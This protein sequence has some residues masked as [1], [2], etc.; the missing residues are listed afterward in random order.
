MEEKFSYL[1]LHNILSP[2]C[3]DG[4]SP[5]YWSKI[6]GEDGGEMLGK[7]KVSRWS[8]TYWN[9]DEAKIRNAEVVLEPPA[10]QLRV[11]TALGVVVLLSSEDTCPHEVHMNSRRHAHNA[12]NIFIPLAWR[13]GGHR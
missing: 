7:S 5:A 4:I 1:T 8:Q 12:S 3:E 9:W 11:L 13:W 6:T 2:C 10:Q